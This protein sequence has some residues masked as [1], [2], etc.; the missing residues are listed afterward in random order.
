LIAQLH[1][2][3][4][5]RGDS[6]TIVAKY[7]VLHYASGSAGAVAVVSGYGVSHPLS[8][9]LFDQNANALLLL[10]LKDWTSFRF[11]REASPFRRSEG[12]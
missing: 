9:W 12:R 10:S 8:Q 7:G 5:V 11:V 6:N 4:L 2:S 1:Y 3:R